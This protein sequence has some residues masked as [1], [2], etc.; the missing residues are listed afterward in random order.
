VTRCSSCNAEIRWV[1]TEANDRPM[2]L[3]P[4]PTESG[5]VQLVGGRARVLEGFD[6]LHAGD[7]GEPLYRSH[8][9][10]CPAAS[11]HRKGRS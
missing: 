3:D 1:R 2:P 5:N 11:K 4:E 7:A 10:T 9:A 6:L 8:F